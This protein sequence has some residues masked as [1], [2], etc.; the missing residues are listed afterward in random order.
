MFFSLLF[1]K[2][3]RDIYRKRTLKIQAEMGANRPHGSRNRNW[4]KIIILSVRE[5]VF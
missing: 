2:A 5:V 4:G 3:I 1:S